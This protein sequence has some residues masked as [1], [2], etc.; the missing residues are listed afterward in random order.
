MNRVI[1]YRGYE[2]EVTPVRRLD[3]FPLDQM[4]DIVGG[5]VEFIE[6]RNG[7]TIVADADGKW[8]DYPYNEKATELMRKSYPGST[9]FIVGNV[10]IC[11]SDMIGD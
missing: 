4:Q 3:H 7:Q 9:D 8:K 2:W 6:L 1:T 5:Y 10:L 11:D